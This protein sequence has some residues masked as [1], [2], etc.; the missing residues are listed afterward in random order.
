MNVVQWMQHAIHW[1]FEATQLVVSP[2][3][4]SV[5]NRQ[6]CELFTSRGMS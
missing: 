6:A 1:K 3:M 4:R 5:A 2:S